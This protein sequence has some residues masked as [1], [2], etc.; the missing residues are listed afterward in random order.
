MKRKGL[1]VLMLVAAGM[2][3]FGG[4]VLAT[5]A[6]G[7]FAGT[8]LANA[9]FDALHLSAHGTPPNPWDLLL[10]TPEQSDVYV[11]FNHWPVGEHR[12][13]HPSGPQPDCP[14]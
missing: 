1:V 3:A 6:T 9:T 5:P 13:A 11:Q 2:A 7:G 8:T 4:K 14:R 10:L 12:M